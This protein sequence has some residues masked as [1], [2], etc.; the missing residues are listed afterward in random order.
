[1]IVTDR[2]KAGSPRRR[3]AALLTAAILLCAAP[4]FAKPRTN[5]VRLWTTWDQNYFYAAFDISDPDIQGESKAANA[6]VGDDDAVALYFQADRATGQTLSPASYRMIVSAAGGAQFAVGSEEGWQQKNI[7]TFK[8]AVRLDGTLNDDQDD[9]TR[10]QVEVAVP[11]KEMGITPDIGAA[12]GFNIAVQ[13]RGENSGSVSLSPDVK[14]EADRDNPSKWQELWLRAAVQPIAI[15]SPGRVMCNRILAHAPIVDG[16][17]LPSEYAEKNVLQIAKPPVDAARHVI[18]DFPIEDLVFGVYHLDFASGPEGA[19]SQAAYVHKPLGGFG[20]WFDPSTIRWHHAQLLDAQRAGIDVVLPVFDGGG[21]ERIAALAAALGDMTALGQ[22]VP[23]VGLLLKAEK[24]ADRQRTWSIIRRFCELVSPRYLAQVRLPQSRGGQSALPVFVRGELALTQ[25]D[26]D[27][28]DRQAAEAFGLRLLWVA[29][30]G[31]RTAAPAADGFAANSRETGWS[32]DESGWIKVAAVTPGCAGGERLLARAA[33]ETYQ[34]AWAAVIEKKPDWV[35]IDSFNDWRDG[36]E[37]AESYEY[38]LRY[39]DATAIR[40]SRFNGQREYAAK[41]LSSFVPREIAPGTLCTARANVRNAGTKPW[42]VTDRVRFTYRWYQGGRLYSQGVAAVPLQKDIPVN[43]SGQISIGVAPLDTDKDPLPAGEWLLVFDLLTPDGRT[44]SSQGDHPLAVA[45]TIGDPPALSAELLSAEIPPLM[46][47]SETYTALVTLRNDGSTAWSTGGSVGVVL[48]AYADADGGRKV[49]E[50][51]TAPIPEETLPGRIVTAQVPVS[52]KPSTAL[53]NKRIMIEAR[54]TADGKAAGAETC[55]PLVASALTAPAQWAPS[56]TPPSRPLAGLE[57]GKAAKFAIDVLNKGPQTWSG[58]AR[59]TADLYSID[60]RLLLANAGTGKLR[61]G[62]KAGE[63]LTANV[64]LK[65]PF[66]PG[67]YVVLWTVRAGDTD[68]SLQPLGGS[69]DAVYMQYLTVTAP[70]LE[71]VDLSAALD[72]DVLASEAN[73]AD[74]QFGDG[75]A[76]FAADLLPPL[77]VPSPT[78]SRLH[79][80]GMFENQSGDAAAARWISFAW[81]SR[82]DGE[83]N[84]VAAKGQT[85]AVTP[86]SYARAHILAA[87]SGDAEEAEFGLIYGGA[88]QKAK[89]RVG[90]WPAPG[91]GDIVAYRTALR[92]TPAGPEAKPAFLYDVVIPVDPSQQLSAIRLPENAAIVVLAMTLEKPAPQNSKKK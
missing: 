57:Y 27:W 59:L 19:A 91:E 51:W 34:S 9:D 87:A 24:G 78:P 22:G 2:P 48:T 75:G 43:G 63:K 20:P 85:I 32:L 60:G 29:G 31:S 82:K 40:P 49:L 33:G 21:E 84:A 71:V 61:R 41:Y 53:A 47:P 83:K 46:M 68:T 80:V 11:W 58:D 14:T 62:I 16:R 26:R 36:S 44:F 55:R 30:G 50:T 52:I 28:F 54:L 67:Q 77:V 39:I 1:M 72:S 5:A 64:E 15:N 90:G 3:A 45:V 25:E 4:A 23:H 66:Y 13:M 35:L 70:G 37:I 76:S 74:G 88:G 7:I 38:G 12:V 73:P 92:M 8:Y 6:P 89:A 17:I 86:G 65:A 81:P 18:R 69:G 56:L 79:P 10:F 42:K